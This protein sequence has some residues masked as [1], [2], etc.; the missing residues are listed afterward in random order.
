MYDLES[1][2]RDLALGWNLA[3]R[4][5]LQMQPQCDVSEGDR[6]MP[7]P[8]LALS[9]LWEIESLG[10]KYRTGDDQKDSPTESKPIS[11]ATQNS[12]WVPWWVMDRPEVNSA[13][14]PHSSTFFSPLFLG[15]WPGSHQ[16]YGKI[17]RAG[18]RREGCLL[19]PEAS[20]WAKAECWSLCVKM[21]IPVPTV[22][23]GGTSERWLGVKGDGHSGWCMPS[24]QSVTLV[25]EAGDKTGNKDFLK[26]LLI[27]QERNLDSVP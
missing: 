25:T 20:E 22:L 6:K 17:K 10:E 27:F 19:S 7:W 8:V 1:R 5:H 18:L 12:L 23:R 4:Q 13:W 9:V 15:V 21:G 3:K 2:D 14:L 11:E 16:S 24:L 26:S